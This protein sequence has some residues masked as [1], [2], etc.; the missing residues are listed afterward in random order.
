[1][2]KKVLVGDEKYK[3]LIGKND[4]FKNYLPDSIKNNKKI[5]IISD[6]NIPTKYIELI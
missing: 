6:K 4:I 2:V 5:F 3:V 1:M